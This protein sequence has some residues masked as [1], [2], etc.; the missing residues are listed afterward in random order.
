M[1]RYFLER[2]MNKDQQ[3]RPLLRAEEIVVGCQLAEAD[4]F[5][6]EVTEIV[7]ESTTKI[8]VRLNSDFSSIKPHWIGGPGILCTFRKSDLVRGFCPRTDRDKRDTVKD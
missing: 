1:R 6:F 7:T 4:G 8:T 5:L 2:E 3:Y